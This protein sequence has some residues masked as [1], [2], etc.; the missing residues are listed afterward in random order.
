MRKQKGFSDLVTL[1]PKI[2]EAIS[3]DW[4]FDVM[5][6]AFEKNYKVIYERDV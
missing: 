3:E 4:Y 2:F 1:L 6:S 5:Q